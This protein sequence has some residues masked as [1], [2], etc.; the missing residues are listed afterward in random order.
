[1]QARANSTP[2]EMRAGLPKLEIPLWLRCVK[3]EP[4]GDQ[5]FPLREILRDSLYYPASGLQGAP[6]QYLAGSIL[7]FVY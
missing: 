3:D 2:N 1:M 4:E 5:P 7:S 6:V